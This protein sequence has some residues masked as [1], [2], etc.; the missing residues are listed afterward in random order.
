MTQLG[1]I[2]ARCAIAVPVLSIRLCNS[3]HATHASA[4]M[5]PVQAGRLLISRGKP[6]MLRTAAALPAST[7]GKGMLPTLAA[8]GAMGMTTSASSM[9]SSSVVRSKQA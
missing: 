5:P 8:M 7:S 3:K 6:R 9:S 4:D 2:Q 1:M